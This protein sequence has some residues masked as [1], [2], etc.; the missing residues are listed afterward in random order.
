MHGYWLRSLSA[1]SGLQATRKSCG[2]YPY[3]ITSLRPYP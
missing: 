3:K 1:R 2:V